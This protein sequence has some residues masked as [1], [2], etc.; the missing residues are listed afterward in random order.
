MGFW[1]ILTKAANN[2]VDTPS[3]W[4]GV[5]KEKGLKGDMISELFQGWHAGFVI[6]DLREDL[7][8]A[9]R[10]GYEDGLREREEQ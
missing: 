2:I 3:Y 4:Y 10:Q 5:G 7:R 6:A 9:Y 8:D 1:D